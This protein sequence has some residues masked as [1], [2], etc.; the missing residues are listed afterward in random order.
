MPEDER[1]EEV[2]TVAGWVTGLLGQIPR[3]GQKVQVGPFEIEI[4]EVSNRR[5]HKIKVETGRAK[6]KEEESSFE[7]HT[8][9]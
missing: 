3:M 7:A 6:T 2:E 1:G 8:K 4:C 5:I 9:G